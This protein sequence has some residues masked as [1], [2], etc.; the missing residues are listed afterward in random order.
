MG[1]GPFLV[2]LGGAVGTLTRHGVS[3]GLGHLDGWSVGWATVLVNVTGAFALGWLAAVLARRR[4]SRAGLLLSTGVLGGYT[5]YSGFALDVVDSA[6]EG[7]PVTALA[8][9]AV[10]LAAGFAACWAGVRLG[11]RTR[12]TEA[13]PV[14]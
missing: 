11:S 8:L 10:T 6:R 1:S 5:T 9:V 4:A 12:A 7:V 2:A 14:R 3:L 13:S